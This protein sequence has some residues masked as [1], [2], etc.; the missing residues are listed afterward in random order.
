MNG[1]IVGGHFPISREILKKLRGKHP[2]YPL[3][4]FQLCSMASFRDG[5]T[6]RGHVLKRGQLITTYGELI[7]VMTYEF[8]HRV[9]KPTVKQL[10][11]MLEWMK[12]VELILINPLISGAFSSK[13]RHW[14]RPPVL[15][16]AYLGLLIT[17]V[18]YTTC[19]VL[20]ASK[21]RRKGRPPSEQG[22]LEEEGTRRIIPP[23]VPQE[24]DER[25]DKE[26]ANRESEESADPS[27]N[28]QT[29][30]QYSEE[31]ESFWKV[32]PK[33]AGKIAAWK[34]W[35]KN[36]RERPALES[37]LSAIEKQKKSDQWKKERGQFIPHPATWINQGRWD[38]E[39]AEV[40][41]HTW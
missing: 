30:K 13:G 41:R 31:F 34:A 15:T 7:D 11:I 19:E 24:V 29:Q 40:G 39:P 36:R 26:T 33:K 25:V 3:L 9:V 6:Y 1:P 10:R 21:G 16:R 4:Y 14:G 17:I 20:E 5:V 22:Q 8:N 23:I 28:S 38:D 12:L 37:I 27:L 2:Q 32:Y 35:Q 18:E